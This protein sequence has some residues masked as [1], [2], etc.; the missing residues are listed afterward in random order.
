MT[1]A[2]PSHLTGVNTASEEALP[3]QRPQMRG[4][5]LTQPPHAGRSTDGPSLS[6]CPICG[7]SNG[8]VCSGERGCLTFKFLQDS[9]ELGRCLGLLPLS[10]HRDSVWRGQATSS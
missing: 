2:S 3:A 10:S 7:G 5:A 8:Y 6:L 9:E 1:S 4:L